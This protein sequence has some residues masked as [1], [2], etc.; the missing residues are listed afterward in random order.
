[1]F[2]DTDRVTLDTTVL[3]EKSKSSWPRPRVFLP[4]LSMQ[5]RGTML[6]IIRVR[7]L[8][9]ISIALFTLLIVL[10]TAHSQQPAQPVP[11]PQAAPAPSSKDN[12]AI[13]SDVDLIVLRV[14]VM[15]GRGKFV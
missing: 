4:S 6:P 15:D 8:A 5:R 14:S 7:S 3:G 9:F 12:Y 2:W 13:R 10:P 1:M 11:P